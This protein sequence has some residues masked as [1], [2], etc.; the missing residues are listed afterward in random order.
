MGPATPPVQGEG[1][2]QAEHLRLEHARRSKPGVFGVFLADSEGHVTEGGRPQQWGPEPGAEVTHLLPRHHQSWTV[3]RGQD[4]RCKALLA[5]D[6]GQGGSQAGALQDTD[7]NGRR[8]TQAREETQAG[9]ETKLA[10]ML[11]FKKN[12]VYYGVIIVF[13]QQRLP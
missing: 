9:E 10:G 3:A 4:E 7:L 12:C 11:F 1:R 5:V 2:Q 6:R 13:L 8:E